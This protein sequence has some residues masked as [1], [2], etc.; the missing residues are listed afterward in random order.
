MLLGTL[1]HQ[2]IDVCYAYNLVSANVVLGQL[3][4][5]SVVLVVILA[6]A[7]KLLSQ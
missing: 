1:S 3:S 5:A 7:A 2:S 4:T 6:C